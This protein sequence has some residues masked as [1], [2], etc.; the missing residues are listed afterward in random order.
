MKVVLN[1]CLAAAV[2]F[3]VSRRVFSWYNHD[4]DDEDEDRGH[5]RPPYQASSHKESYPRD[6]YA[7]TKFTVKTPTIP[8]Q[9]R[10]VSHASRVSPPHAE[11]LPA[12]PLAN[13]LLTGKGEN[14]TAEDLRVMARAMWLEWQEA[15]KRANSA[16][17]KWDYD[18]AARHNRDAQEHKSAVDYLNK[19]A[20]EL[21][22]T[23]KNK[24]PP[25][26][27]ILSRDGK[28]CPRSGILKKKHFF[29]VARVAPMERSIST[30]CTSRKLSSTQS[31]HCSRTHSGMTKWFALSSVR[32]SGS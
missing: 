17:E 6:S 30:T 16:R 22:F 21:I 29:G 31:R 3:F 11:Q 5:S 27:A 9:G 25:H 2:L 8:D 1:V 28:K 20:A 7:R 23:K 14:I 10:N 18:A 12:T 26:R 32:L 24:V 4:E 13:I 15:L 19:M